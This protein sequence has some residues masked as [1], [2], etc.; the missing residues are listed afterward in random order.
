VL[1]AIKV[2]KVFKVR[3]AL[4]DP[5]DLKV[6]RVYKVFVETWAHRV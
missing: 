2:N 1:K 4:T 5:Q 3:K 6:L